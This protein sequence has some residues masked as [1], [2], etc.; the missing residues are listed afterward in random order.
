MKT[1]E[2]ILS[3]YRY[4]GQNYYIFLQKFGI[5]LIYCVNGRPRPVL[6]SMSKFGTSS[7][8][9]CYDPQF[10]FIRDIW[11]IYRWR[12]ICTYVQSMLTLSLN[13]TVTLFALFTETC[14]KFEVNK[15]VSYFN[16]KNTCFYILTDLYTVYRIVQND[17]CCQA[18]C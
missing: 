5:I 9:N 17:C 15:N 2:N 14:L 13:V 6:Q 4:S 8:N 11:Q 1:L 7:T 16:L 12:K 18:I 3:Y 10:P